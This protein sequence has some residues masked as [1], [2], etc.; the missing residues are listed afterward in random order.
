MITPVAP[1]APVGP[2]GPV[3]P[4]K[5]VTPVA[6]TK[7]VFAPIHAPLAA[8]TSVVPTVRPFLTTK[9]ELVANLVHFPHWLII[10]IFSQEYICSANLVRYGHHFFH[11]IRYHYIH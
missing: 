4:C 8:M 1:E 3:A 10:F 9:L 11:T 2:V 6:P 5:P 7:F